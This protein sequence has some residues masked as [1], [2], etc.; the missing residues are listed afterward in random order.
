MAISKR[1]RRA[2]WACFALL[3]LGAVPFL[4]EGGA[5]AWRHWMRAGA[6]A[7]AQRVETQAKRWEQLAC[8]IS[9]DSAPKPPPSLSPAPD[10]PRW[11]AFL[12]LQ[13]EDEKQ[14]MVERIPAL[15]LCCGPDHAVTHKYVPPAPPDIAALG[16]HIALGASVLSMV[17]AEDPQAPADIR[18]TVETAWAT[19]QQQFRSYPFAR[20]NGPS[21]YADCCFAPRLDSTG[22]VSEL[23]VFITPSFYEKLWFKL[24]PHAYGRD[25]F[26][27]WTVW[28]NNVGFRD[29]EVVLPK[30]EGVIRI[31]CIGASTTF[32]GPR[33]DLS[34]PNLLE[35]RL[36]D[37]FHTDRI[38]V[39]NCGVYGLDSAHEKARFQ[40]YL[41]LQ[42]DLLIHYNFVNDTQAVMGGSPPAGMR[43]ADVA[44]ERAGAP[45]WLCL[46]RSAFFGQCFGPWLLPP[47]KQYE[48]RIQAFTMGNMADMVRQA[49]AHGV[50][51]AL[52]STAR[53]DFGHLRGRELDYYRRKYNDPPDKDI[54]SYARAIDVYNRMVKD[55]AKKKG[56]AYIP[57]AEQLTGGTDCFIDHCHLYLNGIDRKAEIIFGAVRDSVAAMITS[58]GSP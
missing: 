58:A 56:V 10:A 37:Q 15:V 12:P 57:V 16:G 26:G 44:E 19:G 6:D 21:C 13:T 52:C 20:K 22:K 49:R 28:T 48:A 53:P 24:R 25:N 31:V 39:I 50:P 51:M 11:Q 17:D 5:V 4:L 3:W 8:R 36:R 18:R 34:Y 55:F 43:P 2:V 46:R 32:E 40:D 1:T 14:A 23:L 45:W 30:P 7:Y 41:D 47:E 27:H 42:P 29:D 9:Q 33:N 54:F 38:E 35:R